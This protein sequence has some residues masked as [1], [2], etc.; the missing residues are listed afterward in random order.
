MS[1]P[2]LKLLKGLAGG[3]IIG[4]AALS[5][6]AFEGG[7]LQPLFAELQARAGA[8]DPDPAA[9]MD[10]A[11]L[12]LLSGDRDNG[13]AVQDLALSH[14]RLYVR[15]GAPG[16]LTVLAICAPGD[17]MAN[18]PIDFLL[19]GS[20][21]TLITLYPGPGGELPAQVPEHDVAFLAAGESEANRP[22]L[23]GLAGRLGDWPRPLLNADPARIADLTRDGVCDLLAGAP[24]IL[25]PRAYRLDR[26][27]LTQIGASAASLFEATGGDDFP[28]IIRPIGSHAG[29]GLEKLN[30]PG[31]LAVY[32]GAQATDR[33]Y[34]SPFIDYAGDDGLYRKARVALI[35][36]RAFVCHMAVS[37]RWMVHYLNADMLENAANREEEAAFMAGFD[38]GFAARHAAAFDQLQAAIGLDYLV[39]DCAETPDGRLLLFEADV[40]MIVHA[41][42]PPDLFPY[43]GPQM[44]KV[45]AAF[46][47]M[48]ERAAGRAA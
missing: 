21:A 14:R 35:G 11:T 24:D 25:A 12:L 33:F 19:E 42:D 40:A 20:G 15:P 44:R 17:T 3:E 30:A 4:L 5:R 32:L 29:T 23:L 39:I 41:M 26:A 7:D 2:G 22:L 9:M 10:A 45:F 13:L 37:P 47:T 27:A 16:G 43:K 46:Q 8:A 34:V 18:T 36:G 31:D 28:V 1:D 48:L 6:L 38:E